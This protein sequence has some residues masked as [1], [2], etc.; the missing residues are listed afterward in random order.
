LNRTPIGTDTPTHI[1][2]IEPPGKD[3]QMIVE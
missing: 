2:L 1:F 3:R